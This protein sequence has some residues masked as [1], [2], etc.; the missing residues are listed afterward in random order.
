MEELISKHEGMKIREMINAQNGMQNDSE[1]EIQREKNP[2]HQSNI[3]KL[4]QA[5]KVQS[6]VYQ[7][8]NLTIKLR[9]RRYRTLTILPTQLFKISQRII[10][11][12]ILHNIPKFSQVKLSNSVSFR[13]GKK[14]I[15]IPISYI[16]VYKIHQIYFLGSSYVAAC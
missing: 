12:E 2:I 10:L 1:D 11:Q 8:I 6:I 5:M 14:E 16:R 7:G 9:N 13:R 4:N 3:Q 15:K